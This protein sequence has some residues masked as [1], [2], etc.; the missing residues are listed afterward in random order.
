MRRSAYLGKD[1]L[2]YFRS[3]RLDP[4]TGKQRLII[5]MVIDADCPPGYVRCEANTVADLERV[6]RE[7]EA[8]KRADFARVDEAHLARCTEKMRV[9]RGR[10]HDALNA[11]TTNKQKDVLRYILK[12]LEEGEKN[13]MPRRIEGHLA[14]ESTEAPLARS[15]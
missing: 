7:Y 2:Y 1:S 12:K 4:V 5:P 10:I 15:N 13:F 8:Q 6:S 11:A 3:I 14:I 9:L